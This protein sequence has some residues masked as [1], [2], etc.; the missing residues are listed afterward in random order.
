MRLANGAASGAS[1]GDGPRRPSFHGSDSHGDAEEASCGHFG[2][3]GHRRVLLHFAFSPFY[4]E[5]VDNVTIWHILN[6]IM[7][8]GVI[9]TLI[10][11]CIQKRG[12]EADR[13]NTNTYICVS[14]AFYAAA[15]LTV[16]FFWNWFDDLT[17]GED[18]QS[19]TRRNYWVVI[20][21]LF[22]VL[23]GAVSAHLW[24]GAPRS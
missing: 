7:A 12:V 11:T 6:W 13:G 4:E 2:P 22:I 18:G 20:N 24:K 21:T 14:V 23:V 15:I 10:T 19:Q 1:T 9:I 8:A 3:H 17:V 5:L 16:L